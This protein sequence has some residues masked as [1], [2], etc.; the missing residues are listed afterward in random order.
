MSDVHAHN[1]V[2]WLDYL[3]HLQSWHTLLSFPH[4]DDSSTYSTPAHYGTLQALFFLY[5]YLAWFGAVCLNAYHIKIHPGGFPLTVI[6][7]WRRLIRDR[8]YTPTRNSLDRSRCSL[9][10]HHD[11]PSYYRATPRE[12]KL[13]ILP[14]RKSYRHKVA[15]SLVS[16]LYLRFGSLRLLEAPDPV[17]NDL[18]WRFMYLNSPF[19]YPY[20]PYALY[21]FISPLVHIVYA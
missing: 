18:I 14:H 8:I 3:I 7:F 1:P 2:V 19:H 6:S 5:T 17:G 15:S 13:L 21:R 20:S 10:H 4:V 12:L 9:V 16:R 11:G